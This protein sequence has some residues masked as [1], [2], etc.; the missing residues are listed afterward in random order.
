MKR[1][2]GI[3]VLIVLAVSASA[4]RS[5]EPTPHYAFKVRPSAKR[6]RARMCHRLQLDSSLGNPA[7]P[8]PVNF[9]SMSQA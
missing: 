9:S 2:L 5:P 8:S 3:V 6:G 7:K 1:L 4:F